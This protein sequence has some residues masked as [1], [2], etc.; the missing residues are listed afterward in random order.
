RG[1]GPPGVRGR[2]S[3]TRRRRRVAPGLPGPHG[4]CPIAGL[5][6]EPHV[7]EA[8]TLRVLVEPLDGL[9]HGPET[10]QVAETDRRHL[11]VPESCL[12]LPE[13]VPLSGRSPGPAPGPPSGSPRRRSTRPTCRTGSPGTW[14]RTGR[15]GRSRW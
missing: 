9:L 11:L 8:R 13:G 7:V 6:L 14:G 4:R 2:S 12:L 1:L 3:R 5:L 10:V 15:R